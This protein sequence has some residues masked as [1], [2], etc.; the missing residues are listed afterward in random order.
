VSMIPDEIVEQVRDSA[1]LVGIIGEAVELKRTGSDY[2]GPCPFHGGTHR[3]FSVIPKKGRY[4]CFVCHESGDV[5]SWLMKRLGM[6]YPT[7][8]REVARRVG[9]VI[10]ERAARAG[11]DPLEPLFGAVAVAEDWFT[12]QLLESAE[13]KGAREYLE[14]REIPL[15]TAALYGLGYAPPGKAFLA[16]MKELGLETRVLLD[17]GVAAARDDGSIVPRFRSRLLFPIHDLRGR[18]CGFGGR[19]LGPGEPKYLNSPE[20]QIFHKGRQLYNLH[21]AKGAIRKEETVILVEGYF[22]VLRLVL[23]GIEHVVAPLG[24]SLTSDQATLLRRFAPA[25]IL[26]YDSDQAGLRATFR[27]GDELLRHSVRVRVATMP[28][29]EDPDTLV[30]RGGAGA[31]EPILGDAIDLLERKVQLLEQ[32]GW[33]EGVDHQREAL[34]RLLPTLRAAADPITRDLYVKEVSERTGVTREVLLQQVTARPDPAY[35][36]VPEART[37]SSSDGPGARDDIPSPDRRDS[38]GQPVRRAG[39]ARRVDAAE[40]ELLRV[41]MREPAWL[42]RAATEV[43][44]EWFETTE[45]REVYEALLRSPENAGSPIFL[46][47]LSPGGRRAWTWLDSIEAKYGVPDPDRTYV[48]ACRTLEV[49]PLRR[50]LATLNREIRGR[51]RAMTSEDFDALV[52]ERARLNREIATRFPEELLKRSIRKG[53]VD[54]R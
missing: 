5:F 26:L 14:G 49:R 18:A 8:V 45:L 19:L 39:R 44:P 7:A 6:D 12:R 52:L 24:T 35:A 43:P 2:R 23:A 36:R 10:P 48:D 33:F 1:D 22:D 28:T 51:E 3:N 25:A 30:R 31:L 53:D 37:R 17:A 15:D 38:A 16:A 40:R 47:Q 21:Q 9:I 46:E 41:L 13:A 32:K 4:Y 11:P 20:N 42:A 29:G 50:Q 27:A 54:A 34:D